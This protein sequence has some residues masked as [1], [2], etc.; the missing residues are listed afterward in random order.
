MPELPVTLSTAP[1]RE[2]QPVRPRRDA[3]DGCPPPHRCA[4]SGV[5][6]PAPTAADAVGEVVTAG[7]HAADSA[8]NADDAAGGLILAPIQPR[9]GEIIV[10]VHGDV[11]LATAP[12]LQAILA[13]AVTAVAT[14]RRR[15]PLATAALPISTGCRARSRPG[16]AD[17]SSVTRKLHPLVRLPRQRTQ[18]SASGGQCGRRLRRPDR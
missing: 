10:R 18:V 5:G 6:S 17:R 16:W 3:A 7:A 12:R 2:G 14:E 11:D 9:R 1:T 15:T 8:H 4:P 13:Q